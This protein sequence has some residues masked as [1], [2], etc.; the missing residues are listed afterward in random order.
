MLFVL[1]LAKIQVT[2]TDGDRDRPENIVYFLA[3]N[4]DMF[5]A[6]MTTGEI[7]MLKVIKV[8]II[9]LRTRF[10]MDYVYIFWRE[11]D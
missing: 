11:I 8:L 6:N 7:F 5:D 3:G 10:S 4:G 9:Y 2:A 1:Y